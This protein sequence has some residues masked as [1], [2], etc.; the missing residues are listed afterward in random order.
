MKKFIMGI[1]EIAE[2]ESTGKEEKNKGRSLGIH[3]N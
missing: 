1:N 2:V 3:S